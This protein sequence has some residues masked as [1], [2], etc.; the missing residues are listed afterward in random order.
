MLLQVSDKILRFDLRETLP[1]FLLLSSIDR[2]TQTDRTLVPHTVA[3]S[4]P[5]PNIEPIS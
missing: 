2:D 1:Y 4:G 3:S 5:T